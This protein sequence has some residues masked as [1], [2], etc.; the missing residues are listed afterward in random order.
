ME[1]Q[2]DIPLTTGFN[3]IIPK[4]VSGRMTKDYYIYFNWDETIDES[5]YDIVIQSTWGEFRNIGNLDK[6]VELPQVIFPPE[7]LILIIPSS[8]YE[9]P[10]FIGTLERGKTYFMSMN[11]II[12]KDYYLL[13]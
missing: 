13:H 7:T 10:S 5:N 6:I 4:D 1:R 8:N 11:N 2:F 9:I 3:F 12:Y